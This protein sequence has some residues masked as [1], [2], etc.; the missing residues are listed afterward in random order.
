MWTRALHL[1][2]ACLRQT[3]EPLADARA[4]LLHWLPFMMLNQFCHSLLNVFFPPSCTACAEFLPQPA[5]Y[6]L[7]KTCVDALEGNNGARCE[8]CDMP[9]AAPRCV[10]CRQLPPAFTAL[11]APWLYGGPLA[12]LVTQC[13]FAPRED[14]AQALGRLIV[15]DTHARTLLQ[16]ADAIVPVPLGKRR[17][18]TRGFNQSAIIARYLSRELNIPV[19][20]ALTRRRETTPQSDLALAERGPNMQ[21]A[22]APNTRVSGTLVLVDD[23]VTSTQTLRQAALALRYGGANA[24]YGIAAAR[25][26]L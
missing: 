1:R 4:R 23:V 5:Y 13:K 14:L 17:R 8:T 18:L 6:A 3:K 19:K 25:T 9:D 2:F 7:C 12:K 24:I 22:F 26:P 20:Y 11:R 15:H 16:K 21:E 10:P